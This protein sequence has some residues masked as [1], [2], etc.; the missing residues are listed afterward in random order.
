MSARN[1]MTYCAGAL[2]SLDPLLAMAA[3]ARPTSDEDYG[4][5]RQVDAENEFFDMVRDALGEPDYTWLTDR[6]NG[7]RCNTDEAID[8]AIAAVRAKRAP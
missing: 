8:E 6:I 3:K 7:P 4:S 5:E 1:R 2:L